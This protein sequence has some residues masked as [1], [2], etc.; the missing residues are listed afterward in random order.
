MT[1]KEVMQLNVD[2]MVELNKLACKIMQADA[3]AENI[4]Y[5][6]RYD[7]VSLFNS[8]VVFNHIWTSV[9]IHKGILT[10]EN[11]T[12]SMEAFVYSINNTF[13][14]DPKDLCKTIIDKMNGTDTEKNSS[15]E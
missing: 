13:G 12:K 14:I 8:L 5:N 3:D 7:E 6:F 15:E 1:S 9:A 4:S 11:V 2:I 10:E